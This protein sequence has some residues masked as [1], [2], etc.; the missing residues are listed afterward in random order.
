MT[1]KPLR[2]AATPGQLPRRRRRIM[3]PRLLRLL[4]A[5]LA[6]LGAIALLVLILGLLDVH[7]VTAHL[8]LH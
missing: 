3:R 5:A 7:A 6:M 2:S 1:T 8:R 4:A